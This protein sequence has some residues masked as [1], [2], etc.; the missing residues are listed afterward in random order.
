[1]IYSILYTFF[2][3][4]YLLLERLIHKKNPKG[5]LF[6]LG[7]KFPQMQVPKNK[8]V[9]WI[10]SVS[11]GETKA[12]IPIISTLRKKDKNCW[13][14]QSTVTDTG[15]EQAKKNQ[16]NIVIYMPFD[17]P[18]LMKKYMK[19]IQP[20]EILIIEND[21]WPN[22]LKQGKRF[23]AKIT[24]KSAHLSDRSF[25]R[26]KKMKWIAKWLYRPIDQIIAQSKLSFDRF[27][28]FVPL[29]KLQLGENLKIH[30]QPEKLSKKELYSWKKKLMIRPKTIAITCTH[31]KEEEMLC[32]ECIPFLQEDPTW[33]IF[34]APRHPDR[35]EKVF[36][37]LQ[38]LP[39][40]SAKLSNHT[41]DVQI[42]LIDRMGFLPIIYQCCHLVILGGSFLKGI[43]GHNPYE[44]LAYQVPILFGPYMEKQKES[45]QYILEKKM[46]RQISIDKL[47]FSIKGILQLSQKV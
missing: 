44:P 32:S 5:F 7:F 24:L 39:V 36:Q 21:L 10:H 22:F 30:I 25:S 45:V 23:G 12:T 33:K 8:T 19:K 46:G 27:S 26:L 15:Y 43:G 37:Y 3:F 4:P 16:V 18:W 38:T 31:E 35:F 2:L 40:S 47:L 42:L 34:L 11:L 9:Y 1:M 20:E 6:K 13:I 14:V 17:F 41:K 29:K 28:C